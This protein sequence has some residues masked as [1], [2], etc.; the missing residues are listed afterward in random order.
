MSEKRKLLPPKNL[1]NKVPRVC[2]FCEHFRQ[3]GFGTGF[4][5]RDPDNTEWDTG[6]A[7]YYEQVCDRFVVMKL[8]QCF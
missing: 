8:P 7:I 2:A 3:D 6:D 5:M 4:C 1:R